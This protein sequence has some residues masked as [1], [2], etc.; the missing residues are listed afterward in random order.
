MNKVRHLHL[1]M[2][3]EI[4]QTLQFF[5]FLFLQYS[6]VYHLYFSHILSNISYF[7]GEKNV[8]PIIL[9]QSGLTSGILQKF[10]FVTLDIQLR[11]INFFTYHKK[12]FDSFLFISFLFSFNVLLLLLLLYFTKYACINSLIYCIRDLHYNYQP[13]LFSFHMVT[14][15]MNE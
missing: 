1:F 6:M 15:K 14:F 4:N 12:S 2:Y 11:F 7:K 9:S 13:F 10:K 5:L 3:S 8:V